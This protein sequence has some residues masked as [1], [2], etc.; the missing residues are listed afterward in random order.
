MALTVKG[1]GYETVEVDL[2]KPP[3]WF[4][5]GSART[6]MPMLVTEGI[7]IHGASTA[8][9]Y[10]DERWTE[11]PLLPGSPAS[12]AEAREWI[13]WLED[14]LQP[15][16][17]AALLEIDP[18]RYEDRRKSLDSV[19]KTL[20]QRLQARAE[21]VGWSPSSYW[22]GE[23]LGMVDLSYAAT[24]M[25]F[26]GLSEFHGWEMPAGL[27]AVK[28]WIG[29]LGADPMVQDTFHEEEVL[30]RVGRYLEIF[31]AVAGG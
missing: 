11:P 13:D 15:T 26:A 4:T 6:R 12:R 27:P 22:H 31:R 23:K 3:G 9:E 30:E 2:L 7:T 10:I 1:V 24:F 14:K 17:E 28:A 5:E 18:Q 29:T 21:S 19:L 8:N 25:R 16:Y 20:E